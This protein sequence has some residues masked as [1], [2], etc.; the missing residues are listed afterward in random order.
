MQK[1]V[2]NNTPNKIVPLE[3][4]MSEMKKVFIVDDNPGKL[5]DLSKSARILFPEVEI[6][7]FEYAN[8][9]LCAVAKSRDA[10]IANPDQYLAIVDMQ[11]PPYAGGRIN[12]DGGY[13]ILAEME[14][15]GLRCPAVVASSESID[16]HRA[17][18]TYEFYEGF[19]P[20][21]VY[22]T[23][24]AHLRKVLEAYVSDEPST[25]REG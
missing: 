15:L 11:L 13:N 16:E 17:V 5:A 25:D 4:E 6:E 9:M 21:Y 20:Y 24:T 14:R 3:K 2:D 23:P 22:T 10:I 18:D 1:D 12:L 7:E 19:V 8:P